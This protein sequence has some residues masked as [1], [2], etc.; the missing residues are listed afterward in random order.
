MSL[1]HQSTK[2]LGKKL[3]AL[4]DTH[5]FNS[6]MNVA[7]V[8]YNLRGLEFSSKAPSSVFL[9]LSISGDLLNETILE[10]CWSTFEKVLHL[11]VSI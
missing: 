10:R 11:A 7:G 3:D 9:K 2:N 5:T 6:T 4:V 1:Y 8:E